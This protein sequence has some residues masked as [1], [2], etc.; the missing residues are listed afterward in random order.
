MQPVV[1]PQD[2]GSPP[3]Q[4]QLDHFKKALMQRFNVEDEGDLTDLLGIEFTR[5]ESAVEIRQTA[6]I[7]KLAKEFFPDGVPST[8]QAN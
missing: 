6:Y 2:R 3:Q 5:H 1:W 8:A 7:E 4:L